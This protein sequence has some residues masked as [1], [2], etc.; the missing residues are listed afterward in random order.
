MG[1]RMLDLGYC[2]NAAVRIVVGMVIARIRERIDVVKL[3]PLKGRHRGILYEHFIVVILDDS[4]TAHRIGVFILCGKRLCI[5]CLI[6]FKSIEISDLDIVV[7]D[8]IPRLAEVHASAHVA[9][10]LYGHA[11]IKK[12]GNAAN[13]VLAHTVGKDIRAA[14]DKHAAAHPVLPIIVMRKAAQGCLKSADYDRHVTKRLSYSV[15]IY[16]HGAVG[17]MTHFSARAVIVVGAF[18]F[19]NGIVRDHRVDVS[20]GN[21]K[22]EARATEALE[23]LTGLVIGL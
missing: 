10:F 9:Y 4:L 14:V 21:E 15:A 1:Y 11:L 12:G 23:I 13:D 6:V 2:G 20:R 16:D 18:L 8:L 3:L 19:G 22:A 7:E 17:S 5:G